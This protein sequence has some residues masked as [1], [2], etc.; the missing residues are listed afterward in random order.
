V[1]LKVCDGGFLSSWEYLWGGGAL[2][3]GKE[4]RMTQVSVLRVKM[5]AA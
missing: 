4:R 3:T 1:V 5:E 2:C